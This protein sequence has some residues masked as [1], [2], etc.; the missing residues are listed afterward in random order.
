M[1]SRD[2]FLSLCQ[3]L[4]GLGDLGAI[5]FGEC[6]QHGLQAVTHSAQGRQVLGLVGQVASFDIDLELGQT[7]LP[8]H[9]EQLRIAIEMG[10]DGMALKVLQ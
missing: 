7:G 4:E 9:H 1:L 2:Q 5:F 3:L 8:I 10:L 6:V